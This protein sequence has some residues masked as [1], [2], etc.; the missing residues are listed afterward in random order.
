MGAFS[1]LTQFF[2]RPERMF[3]PMDDPFIQLDRAKAASELKLRERGEEHG[4]QNLPPSTIEDLDNVEAEVAVFVSELYSRAQIDAS[5]SLRTY[6]GRLSDLTL[7]TKLSSVSNAT[8]TA[9]GDFKKEVANRLNRLSNSRD[10][11]ASSYQELRQ[12][13]ADHGLQRPAH[14]VPPSISTY[15]TIALAW[16]AETVLNAFLL[17]LNDSM[18]YLGGI[19]A[20]A[21]VGA[22]NVLLAAFVGRNVWP[23]VYSRKLTPRLL[24]WAGGLTWIAFA[25]LWNLGAAHYR[26]AKSMGLPNPEQRALD[27]FGLGLSSI[28]SWGLLLAGLVFAASAAMAAFK[29]DDPLPGYGPVNRRHI[30][31]CEDYAEEVERATDEISKIRDEAIAAATEVRDELARQF[32]E[33]IQ[34]LTARAALCKRF[35]EH[36]AHLEQVANALLQD[37]RTSNLSKRSSAPPA[38]FNRRWKLPRSVPSPA[39]TAAISEA[40]IRDAEASLE[41]AIFE[42]TKGFDV[43]ILQFE[44]LDRLKERLSIA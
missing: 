10:A 40:E 32:A 13:R 21:T 4:Q 17:R 6:D 33:R 39:P 30:S 44:P 1:K 42:V 41:R 35:E 18:G 23:H 19:V 38:S 25:V 3:A 8:S 12:F 11:I 29:A 16:L 36:G 26:D 7:L 20:A 14:S 2:T 43:A 34:I 9:I 28:Y 15:G 22:I 5:N 24:A 27:M 31:R 37:Y